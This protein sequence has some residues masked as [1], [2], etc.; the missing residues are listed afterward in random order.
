MSI[1]QIFSYVYLFIIW[2]KTNTDFLIIFDK[3]FGATSYIIF[4]LKALSLLRASTK[5]GFNSIAFS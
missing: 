1:M 4:S 5:S 3:P 2:F